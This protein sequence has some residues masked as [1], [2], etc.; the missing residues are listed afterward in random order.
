MRYLLTIA[1]LLLLLG[2]KK[3]PEVEPGSIQ[4]F[5]HQGGGTF[6]IGKNIPGNTLQSMELGAFEYGLKGLEID[7]QLSSDSVPFLFHDASLWALANEEGMVNDHPAS[8]LSKIRYHSTFHGNDGGPFYL[9][10]LDEALP[11]F[12]TPAYGIEFFFDAKLNFAEG[13]DNDLLQ[14]TLAHKMLD[15]ID[16]YEMQ[17]RTIVASN[18]NHF[19]N[20]FQAFI[21]EVRLVYYGPNVEA[22]INNAY[23]EGYW[24]I[25]FDHESTTASGVQQT[26]A[27]GLKYVSW[28]ARTK[29]TS[30]KL[31]EAK[32]D[33]II[34]DNIPYMMEVVQ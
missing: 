8:T 22:A 28:G 9:A 24:G 21:P 12:A 30:H 7:V 33:V 10:R 25:G 31:L 15:L 34:T 16:R 26:H 27:A 32:P 29:S 11:R 2:C 3:T 19:L 18:S 17:Y 14:T 20:T 5:G 6:G 1:T 4:L 13:A 23:T